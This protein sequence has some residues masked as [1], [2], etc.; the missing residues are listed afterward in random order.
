MQLSEVKRKFPTTPFGMRDDDEVLVDKI[1]KRPRPEGTKFVPSY[2]PLDVYSPRCSTI[3]LSRR[4]Q[5]LAA[6]T[7]ADAGPTGPTEMPDPRSVAIA[8]R[9][10]VDEFMQ[11]NPQQERWWDD[12]TD[13]TYMPLPPPVPPERQIRGVRLRIGRGGR[14]HVDRRPVSVGSSGGAT[15]GEVNRLESLQFT[16]RWPRGESSA[17]GGSGEGSGLALKLKSG[18]MVS[19]EEFE[20]AIVM[21]ERWRYDR[22]ER[23]EESADQPIVVD[24]YADRCVTFSSPVHL[25]I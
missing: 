25:I 17:A 3:R 9:K 23:L 1:V 7:T 19:E 8:N 18:E 16:M 13:A 20:R 22:D 4:P 15:R 12:L 21:S 2:L 5:N 14:R 11:R 24:D 10:K 6:S